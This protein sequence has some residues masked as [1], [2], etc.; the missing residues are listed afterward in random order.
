M[1]AIE[2]L[3]QQH[4][5]VERLFQRF[6]KLGDDDEDEKSRLFAVI[7]DK[8]AIHAAIE[9]KIFYP[10]LKT[11]STEDELYEAAEEHLSVKRVIADLLALA[12]SEP[13]FDAAMTGLKDLVLHHVEEER[14]NILPRARK[15][16]DRDMQKAIGQEMKAMEDASEEP[17][18]RNPVPTEPAEPAPPAFGASPCPPRVPQTPK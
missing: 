12:P 6:E 7:A 5:E 11:E 4:D 2:L 1:S 9:E 10:S 16:L 18:P 14:A 8:L 3:E 13:R 15:L 17:E